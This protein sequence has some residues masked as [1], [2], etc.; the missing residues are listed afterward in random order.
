MENFPTWADYLLA[1]VFGLVLPLTSGI[2][3]AAA[4]KQ[5]V[6]L[7]N[8]PM[9]R[10]FYLGNS[11]F[12]F[13]IAAVVLLVWLLY[14]RPIE[15]LGFRMPGTDFHTITLILS[16]LFLFLYMADSLYSSW[17]MRHEPDA[18]N[19]L[20]EKAPFMPTEKD[21]LPTYIIMCIS[22]AVFEEI[23]FRG[24]LISFFAKIFQGIPGAVTWAL[25]APAIIFSIAHY[26]QGAKAVF[27]IA[28]LSFLFG[29]IYWYSGSLIPVIILHFIVD[30]VSGLLCVYYAGEKGK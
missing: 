11:F 30:L 23:V 4:F 24:F 27:K 7:F 17:E 25:L 13:L 28:V 16:G 19:D 22:A 15:A 6:L 8:G 14:R 2:R 9:R 1:I 18:A 10:R 26:Y 20:L 29:M 3:S 5:K 12:L 21:D